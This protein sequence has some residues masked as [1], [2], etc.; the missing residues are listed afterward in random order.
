MN[1]SCCTCPPLHGLC[2]RCACLLSQLQ[3]YF[4]DGFLRCPRGDT[5]P[6]ILSTT[7][8]WRPD[9]TAQFERVAQQFAVSVAT[10]ASQILRCPPVRTFVMYELDPVDGMKPVVRVMPDFPWKMDL[11]DLTVLT[12]LTDPLNQ[13]LVDALKQL[14]PAAAAHCGDFRWR[15]TV[16]HLEDGYDASLFR[17]K[18]FR[19]MARSRG[20]DV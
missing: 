2:P 7:L 8:P 6:A 17:L 20:I 18:F 16:R 10:T 19:R 9:S 12:A 1:S 5:W 14:H 4:P 11:R 15:W 3:P 13:R